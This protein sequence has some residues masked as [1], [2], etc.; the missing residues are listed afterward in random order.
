MPFTSVAQMR[1]WENNS[2]QNGVNPQAVIDQVGRK[3]SNTLHQCA[4]PGDSI[5]ILTGKGHNGDDGRAALPHLKRFRAELIQIHSIENDLPLVLESIQRKPGWIV[6]ALF[7][8]GLNRP[9]S[10]SWCRAIQ[11]I[12]QSGSKILAVD[13]PSGLNGDTGEPMGAAVKSTITLTI[14][15]PKIGLLN[16]RARP[17]VGRLE[18]ADDIGLIG[19]PEASGVDWVLSKDLE[20]YPPSRDSFSHK[21]TYGHLGI[22]AG[23]QGF[24]GAGIL[25]ARAAQRAQPGLITLIT[26]PEVYPVSAGQLQ[27]VMVDCWSE[28]SDLFRKVDALLVGPGLASNSIPDSLKDWFRQQWRSFQGPVVADASALDW[29]SGESGN[30]NNSNPHLRIITPH[31]AEASRMLQCSIADVESNRTESLRKLSQTFNHCWVVL[32]GAQTLIGNSEGAIRVNSTGN[33]HLAQGGSGDVLGGYLAG[34]VVQPFLQQ[35]ILQTLSFAVWQH[36][37]TAD[38]LCKLRRNWVVEDLAAEIGNF[39]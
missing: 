1:D 17:Y 16:A 24:H 28:H 31:P 23:S 35:N 22:V 12:N 34:L 30:K 13:I 4:Q 33:P 14:G 27:A 21:G 5:L 8:I 9:L 32:K 6:D 18:L 37:K 38:E 10:E 19:R 3:I 26:Q 11:A 36:G 2:W 25:A 39:L 29:L 20:N 15:A 7:G